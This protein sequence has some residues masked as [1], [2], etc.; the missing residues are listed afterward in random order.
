MSSEKKKHYKKSKKEGNMYEP[1]ILKKDLQY[2]C[3][4]CGELPI[5]GKRFTCDVCEDFG[6]SYP[7]A[8][9]VL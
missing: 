9:T 8:A 4:L 5:T 1:C 6:E 3:D 2:S 7:R